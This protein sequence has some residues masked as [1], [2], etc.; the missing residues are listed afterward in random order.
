MKKII[1]TLIC[2]SFLLFTFGCSNRESENRE[3]L[4][5]SECVKLCDS[6]NLTYYTSDIQM[7]DG[8]CNINCECRIKKDLTIKFD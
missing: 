7:T 6:Y 5:A 4:C 1:L 2:L 8:Y 3:I